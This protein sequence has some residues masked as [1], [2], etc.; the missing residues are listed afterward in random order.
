MSFVQFQQETDMQRM[1][2]ECV[3]ESD[4]FCQIFWHIQA[5]NTVS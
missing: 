2:M 1:E 3:I 5:N 4:G